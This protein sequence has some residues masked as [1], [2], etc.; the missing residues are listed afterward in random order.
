MPA[1]KNIFGIV[2][3]LPVLV[4][5]AISIV[6]LLALS[7]TKPEKE[8]QITSQKVL[9]EG[10][11]ND[12]LSGTDSSGSSESSGSGSG[13]RSK[14]EEKMETVLEDGTVIRTEVKDGEVRTDTRFP[15][16]IKV[17]TREEEDRTRVD[18]YEGGTKLRLER[19]DD[20]VIVKLEN[21]EGEEVELPEQEEEEIFKIEEREEGDVKVRA[22]GLGFLISAG[23]LG[24]QTD[25]PISVDLETN[26]L[27]VTT[28]AGEKVVTVLPDRAVFNMLA[29]NVIN[30]VQG[31][32]FTEQVGT[33]LTLEDIVN[34]IATEEG[35]LAY[36]IPGV[37]N[38]KFLGFI[39][40]GVAKTAIVSVETGQLLEVKQPILL[41]L[42]DAFSVQ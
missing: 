42:L 28:P 26:E 13:D 11:E 5:A 16:G 14:E 9:S 30:Q 18:I 41:R 21:E 3:I 2:H 8:S 27:R 38:Q 6:A 29:A 1:R 17:K 36:K 35:I 4:V 24:A 31:L 12:D 15:S 23:E 19:E 10:S 20:R 33:G 25:F 40:V 32:P 37:S 34:L 7:S 22:F 39:P